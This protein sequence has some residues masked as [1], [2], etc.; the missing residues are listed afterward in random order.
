MLCGTPELLQQ[1]A[2]RL[3]AHADA[4]AP[5]EEWFE[6]IEGVLNDLVARGDARIVEPPLRELVTRYATLLLDPR[7]NSWS[8]EDDD[9]G[10]TPPCFAT[11][12]GPMMPRIVD[13]VRV[14]VRGTPPL[15]ATERELAREVV[16]R[17][18]RNA[19]TSDPADHALELLAGLVALDV[20]GALAALVAVAKKRRPGCWRCGR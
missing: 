16:A 11:T 1:W 20:D 13:A 19:V 2:A 9:D 6:A 5:T 15:S 18:E 3:L 12:G 4:H 17:L 14:L 8:D 7:W 10:D